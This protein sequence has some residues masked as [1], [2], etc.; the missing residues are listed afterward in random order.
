[1]PT[2]RSFL[3]RTLAFAGAMLGLPAVTKAADY[4]ST[5]P[6]LM[7]KT[8]PRIT[9]RLDGP[10]LYHRD[11]WAEIRSLERFYEERMGMSELLY[12]TFTTEDAE[13]SY[14]IIHQSSISPFP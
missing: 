12:G 13:R 2:R 1:M 7:G 5:L 14:F 9:D 11:T 8:L 4:D 3:K 6:L 10:T